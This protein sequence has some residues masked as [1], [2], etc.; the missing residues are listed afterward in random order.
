MAVLAHEHVR[1]LQISV[2]NLLG[3]DVVEA[4]RQFADLTQEI[5][6][7]RLDLTAAGTFRQELRTHRVARAGSDE[8]EG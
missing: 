1:Q 2:Q 8:L 3:V 7:Q 6:R 5:S 4:C